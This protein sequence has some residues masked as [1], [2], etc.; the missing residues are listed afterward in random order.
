MDSMFTKDSLEDRVLLENILE[1][2]H[3]S[4][5]DMGVRTVEFGL[6]TDQ[7]HGCFLVEGRISSNGYKEECVIDLEFIESPEFVELKNTSIYF[8]EV[9]SPPYK[10]VRNGDEVEAKSLRDVHEQIMS[11][12]R[13]GVAIQRYKGLGE[14]NPGQLWDTTMNPENRTVLQVKI[15]DAVAADETFT[16]L[17][18]DVVEPRRRFIEENALNV[19]NLDI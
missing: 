16:I 6:E 18:G 14:M 10:V 3:C 5:M 15:E 4:L 13:K 9:G 7:E 17:M 11:F 1:R 8:E 19:V 2:A 12:G